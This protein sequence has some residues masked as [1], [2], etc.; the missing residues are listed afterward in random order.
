MRKKDFEA[1]LQSVREMKA[2]K[3]GTLSPAR[4]TTI[5]VQNVKA[6]RGKLKMS[7][8]KFAQLVGVSV[9]T[10]ADAFGHRGFDDD[11]GFSPSGSS[12]NG[13]SSG[14]RGFQMTNDKSQMTN[15]KWS[16]P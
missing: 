15:D 10:L 2:I 14:A 7:Q 5:V 6:L 3:K 16:L 4:E 9:P 11:R 1:F 12:A 13:G 8:S